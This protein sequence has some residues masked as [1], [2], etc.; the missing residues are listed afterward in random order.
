MTGAPHQTPFFADTFQIPVLFCRLV[1]RELFFCVTGTPVTRSFTR[2]NFV[3]SALCTPS[4]FYRSL[5][6]LPLSEMPCAG[7]W[8]LKSP[9]FCSPLCFYW[10]TPR[11]MVI[12]ISLPRI[13][14]RCV[15]L[16]VF[17]WN[18]DI[19]TKYS[20]VPL[21]DI[22]FLISHSCFLSPF[23]GHQFDRN[24]EPS[25]RPSHARIQHGDPW[26]CFFSFLLLSIEVCRRFGAL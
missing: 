18:S 17:F 23:T 15:P 4:A 8:T 5:C 6:S 1:V 14:Q 26:L 22:E 12:L 9:P 16:H 10:A 13:A 20:F 19:Q 21:Y 3:S 2:G 11:F 24:C 7:T 25:C